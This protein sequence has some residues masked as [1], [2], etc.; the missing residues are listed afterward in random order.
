MKKILA[1]D[2]DHHADYKQFLLSRARRTNPDWGNSFRFFESL[3]LVINSGKFDT[4]LMTNK[5]VLLRNV[6]R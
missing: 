2:W 6:D 1:T 4:K 5:M 3:G